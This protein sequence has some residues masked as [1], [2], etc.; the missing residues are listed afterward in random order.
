[1]IDAVLKFADATTAKAALASHAP[2]D[3]Q[4]VRQWAFDHVLPVTVWRNSQDVT[5]GQGNATHT[6]LAGFF[7]LVS[8]AQVVPALRDLAAVQFVVDR[9]AANARTPGAVLKSNVSNAVLQDLR[10]SPV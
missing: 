9:D 1:M 4:G 7:V 3:D 2:T 5:D 10:M 6:P 8:L